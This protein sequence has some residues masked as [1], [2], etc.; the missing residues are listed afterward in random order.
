MKA[1]PRQTSA[2]DIDGPSDVDL[3]R[4]DDD[5]GFR[6]PMIPGARELVMPTTFGKHAVVIPD[7]PTTT[8][9]ATIATRYRGGSGAPNQRRPAHEGSA[10]KR[11]GRTL[12]RFLIGH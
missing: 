11:L 9:P 4:L 10:W 5:G 6:T 12:R 1:R 2:T 7:S 3:A 8:D